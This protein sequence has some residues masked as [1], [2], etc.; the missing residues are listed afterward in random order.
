LV[1][2]KKAI[3]GQFFSLLFFDG[4]KFFLFNIVQTKHPFKYC[5]Q[6]FKNC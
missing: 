4:T 3:R 5:F 6:L 2:I 1:I